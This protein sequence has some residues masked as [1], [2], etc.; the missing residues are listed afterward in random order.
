MQ[1]TYSF[2]TNPYTTVKWSAPT[3]DNFYYADG[4]TA[5]E[6]HEPRICCIAT[7]RILGESCSAMD[8]SN[9]SKWTKS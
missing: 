1:K 4:T 5:T 2:E 3:E 7:V 6:E 8:D 9:P